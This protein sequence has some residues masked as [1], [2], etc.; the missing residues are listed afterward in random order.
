[1][2]NHRLLIQGCL[3]CASQQSGFDQFK[4]D[5]WYQGLQVT[6]PESPSKSAVS[7]DFQASIA[8]EDVICESIV[9][10]VFGLG[11]LP[12]DKELKRT[13]F[14]RIAAYARERFLQTAL[15]VHDAEHICEDITYSAPLAIAA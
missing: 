5:L 12:I 2:R 14:A 10:R 4:D 15:V 3:A 7:L 8:A 1:M 11:R 6:L 9:I 13:S